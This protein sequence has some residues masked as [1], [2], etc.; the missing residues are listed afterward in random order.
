MES[1]EAAGAD[2]VAIDAPPDESAGRW[3]RREPGRYGD[4]SVVDRQAEELR[5]VEE[6]FPP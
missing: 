3:Q 1:Q 2:E 4:V 6:I 5:E